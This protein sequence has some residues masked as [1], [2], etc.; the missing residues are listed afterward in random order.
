WDS[1][2]R[3][4]DVK[5]GQPA[6]RLLRR[7]RR[8]RRE[9]HDHG[10]EQRARIRGGRE[11]HDQQYDERAPRVAESPHDARN[12]Y[13]MPITIAANPIRPAASPIP[14]EA[15]PLR[16]PSDVRMRRRDRAPDQIANGAKTPNQRPRRPRTSARVAARS[17]VL[18]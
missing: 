10:D 4:L 16:A 12:Q 5:P 3:V 13:A 11:Q 15:R 9:L 2:A 7:S 18:G 8:K 6:A 17:R 14:A 1:I